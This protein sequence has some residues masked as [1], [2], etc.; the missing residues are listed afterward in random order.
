[1]PPVV[2]NLMASR[3]VL[4]EAISPE[5]M[6]RQIADDLPVHRLSHAPS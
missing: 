2:S 1:M 5:S 6:Y 4:R 3:T